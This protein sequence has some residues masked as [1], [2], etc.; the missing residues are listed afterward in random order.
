MSREGAAR[1]EWADRAVARFG[2]RFRE[3]ARL[4]ADRSVVEPLAVE[5][6]PVIEALL[7]GLAAADRP[8]PDAI[9][10]RE[11]L[12]LTS[13]LGRRAAVLGA[14]PSTALGIGACLVA[15]VAEQA[16]EVDALSESLTAVALEGYVAARE[17]GISELAARRMADA[18]AVVEPAPGCVAVLPG[19]VQDEAEL[20]RAF[21]EVGRRLL[22][23]G[24]RACVV[25]VGGLAEPDRERARRV[26]GVHATC[27]ML[28]VSCVYTEVADAWLD[29]ARDAGL[30]LEHVRIE[31][32]F[33]SGLRV[34]LSACGVELRTRAGLADVLRRIV[35]PRRSG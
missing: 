32:D 2:E 6:R 33:A 26:F 9:A 22:E 14:T 27:V 4:H 10:L 7:E 30:A 1:P 18:I 24:A 23:T 3:R 8:H 17:E 5:A 34:A 13:L 19:G 15:A 11:A 29:A 28:G 20:E 35:S 16:P 12:T 25:H 21:D 31:P